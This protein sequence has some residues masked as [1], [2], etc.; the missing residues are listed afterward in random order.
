MGLHGLIRSHL[1]HAS[2]RKSGETAADRTMAAMESIL[3]VNTP[4][5]FVLAVASADS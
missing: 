4:Q 2:P 1:F 5:I 3:M